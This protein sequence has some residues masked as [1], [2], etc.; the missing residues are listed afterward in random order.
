[1]IRGMYYFSRKWKKCGVLISGELEAS[2]AEAQKDFNR[3]INIH[4]NQEHN[5]GDIQGGTRPKIHEEFKKEAV[6]EENRQKVY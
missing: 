5:N 1:M 4:H 2:E 6:S 3:K